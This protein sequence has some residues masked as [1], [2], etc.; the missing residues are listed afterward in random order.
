[1]SLDNLEE[2]KRKMYD[3][4]FKIWIFGD[5]G[6]GKTT[7]VNKYLTGVFKADTTITIGVDF[8]I[9][10]L[11]MN[12]LKVRLQI[13]DFAG[14][15]RFR[16][17]LPGYVRGSAGGIFMYDITRFASLKN[18][19]GWLQV[20][21]TDIQKTPQLIPILLVGGK[22]DLEEYRTVSTKDALDIAKSFNLNGFIECSAKNGENIDVIFE[23]IANVML[24]RAGL[25]QP[26]EDY[27]KIKISY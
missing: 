7:L 19:N 12:G 15:E 16:F 20:L 9:K 22:T 14:E 25:I 26:N 1:C 11:E 10:T 23:T 2:E 18:I 8:H 5:G 3:A 17:L 4:V 21:N 27:N 13:W 6:V 24:E